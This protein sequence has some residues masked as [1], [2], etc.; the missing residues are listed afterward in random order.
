MMKKVV[1]TIVFIFLIF[2]ASALFSSST[3]TEISFEEISKLCKEEKFM[4]DT[5]YLGEFFPIR[6][7]PRSGKLASYCDP[8][9]IIM[10]A[11]KKP[12]NGKVFLLFKNE[13]SKEAKNIGTNFRRFKIEYI[14]GVMQGKFPVVEVKK[15]YTKQ[16][17]ELQEQE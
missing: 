1:L 10:M 7:F 15:I 3:H 14:T 9:S 17:E 11:E 13:N 4:A 12:E 16:T 5:S 6:I 8:G 2:G